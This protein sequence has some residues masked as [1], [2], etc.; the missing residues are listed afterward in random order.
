MI[1]DPRIVINHLRR[2]LPCIR[3]LRVNMNLL[4]CFSLNRQH[5]NLRVNAFKAKIDERESSG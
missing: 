2:M 3:G 4:R 1:P 5:A